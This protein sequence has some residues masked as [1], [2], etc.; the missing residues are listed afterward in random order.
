VERLVAK[1]GSQV[2][3]IFETPPPRRSLY[4]CCANEIGQL[5]GEIHPDSPKFGLLVVM[6]ASG[7]G[8]KEI[9]EAASGLLDKGLVYLCAWGPDCKRVHD[10][11]DVAALDV[12]KQLTGD[13][14]IM[15]TSHSDEFLRE[16]VWYFA[17]SAFPTKC[18]SEL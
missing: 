17:H 4:L 3:C 6:D 11:F 1:F 16:A 2:S 10:L 5:V 15:T 7:V 18:F 8:S 14:V 9:L 13:D 12:N